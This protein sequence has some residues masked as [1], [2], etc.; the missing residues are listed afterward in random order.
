MTFNRNTIPII[1][2]IMGK[3]FREEEKL[4]L[5]ECKD[6][7]DKRN[8]IYANFTIKGKIYTDEARLCSSEI[9][10]VVKHF[11]FIGKK[12]LWYEMV[13]EKPL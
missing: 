3:R 13:N 10:K 5:E 9:N 11:G 6:C 2:E 1:P 4:H 8:E 12:C 7:Q